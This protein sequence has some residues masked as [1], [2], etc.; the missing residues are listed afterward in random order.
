MRALVVDS[1]GAPADLTVR[2]VE[3]PAIGT[4]E[5]LLRV[6][7]AAVNRSDVLNVLGLPITTYPRI[8]GRD[9]AGTVVEGPPELVGKAFWGTGSGDLG[10]TRDGS[11]AELLALPSQALVPLPEGLSLQQAGA[12]GLSYAVAADGLS[13]AGFH[14]AAQTVLVTG[15]AGGVGSA[16]TAIALWRGARLIAA[17]RDEAEREAVLGAHPDADVLVSGEHELAPAVRER[18]GGLGADIVFDTVGNPVFA[19]AAAALGREGRML[20]I[21]GAPAPVEFDLLSF[22][23]TGGAILAVNSTRADSVWVADLLR[24]LLP[25]F[26][27]GALPAPQIELEVPLEDSAKAFLA[28]QRGGLRGRAL[29][30]MA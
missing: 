12:A 21:T 30:R 24:G 11:H 27:S 18:T 3:P 22:Y 6:A 16:A 29:I 9:F 8:T 20:V 25:G 26:V 15:A 14:G 7:A 23:R 1:P 4:G 28:V 5:V 2:E 13:L 10:F 17:V 19:A